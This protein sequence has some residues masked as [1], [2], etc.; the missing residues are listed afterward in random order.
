MTVPNSTAAMMSINQK[1]AGTAAGLGSAI[2]IGGGAS[3]SA[4]ANFLLVPGS[5][6]VPLLVL[7]WISVFVG[8]P[9]V[10]YAVY[11]SK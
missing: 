11:R 5:S 1:L 2:M 7:M 4:V 6:E 9:A 3:L 8:L 10:L